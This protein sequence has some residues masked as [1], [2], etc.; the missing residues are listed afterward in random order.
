MPAPNRRPLALAIAL[1]ALA[2]T[3]CMTS[4]G[5][6][7]HYNVAFDS[8]GP[9]WKEASHTESSGV[10]TRE[11][12]RPGETLG[13]WRELLTVQ[14]FDRA[15]SKFPAPAA[16]EDSLRRQ[17]TARCPGVVW[18]RVAADSA[19]AL[20]EWHVS[21]CPAQPDQYQI[22]RVFESRGARA[23]VAYSRKGA[24]MPDSVRADWLKRLGAARFTT[25]PAR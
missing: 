8:P 9:P 12:V 22:A 3:A 19:S 24:T 1:L 13:D 21:G 10:M 6:R 18:N 2:A 15:H 11:Y 7:Y 20:Y 23:R 17:E 25:S 5:Q 14:V 4:R 16:A